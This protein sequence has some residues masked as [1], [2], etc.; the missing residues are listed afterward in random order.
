M[1][2]LGAIWPPSLVQG[3]QSLQAELSEPE[4]HIILVSLLWVT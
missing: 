2:S 1:S 3:V 4:K